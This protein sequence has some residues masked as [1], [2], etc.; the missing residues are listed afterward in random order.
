MSV[1]HTHGLQFNLSV[2]D[3][4]PF[5]ST[6]ATTSSFFH[7]QYVTYGRLSYQ[8]S[9]HWEELESYW[10]QKLITLLE[11]DYL[12]VLDEWEVSRELISITSTRLGTGQFGIV[13][14]GTLRTRDENGESIDLPVAVKVLKGNFT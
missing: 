6:Y 14:K 8:E 4:Q 12:T 3:L 7:I 9:M 13:K 1:N 11:F 10:W 5:V 2:E